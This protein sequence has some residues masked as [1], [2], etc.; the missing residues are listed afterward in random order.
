[1]EKSI[2]NAA[3]GVH[4]KVLELCRNIGPGDVLDAPSGQGSLSDS[5]AEAGFNV[6]A[7]DIDDSA[8]RKG[9]SG[10]TFTKGDLNA[11]LP[12]P[13]SSFDCVVCVE[14]IEHLENPYHILRQ[15]ARV[16]KPKGLLIITTPNILN[17]ASR[18]KFLL[19]G[20]FR[21]YNS[22]I[23]IADRSLAGHIH[24]TGFPELEYALAKAGFK[25]EEVTTNTGMKRWCALR[26]GV[27]ALCRWA[28]KTFNKAHNPVLC[29]VE[30]LFG[31]IV[32]VKA[33]K[34]L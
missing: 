19:F 8:F 26:S 34:D 13:D 33:R 3:A 18:M 23:E 9:R 16:L 20:S 24:P 28:G 15:F 31:E 11:G 5:L 32:I 22:K 7:F 10:V 14:G 29:S 4:E 25:I 2:P 6:S 21:Y 30:L 12:Y 17:L 27:G 1:M